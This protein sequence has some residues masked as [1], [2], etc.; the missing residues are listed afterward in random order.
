MESSKDLILVTR[1]LILLVLSSNDAAAALSPEGAQNQVTENKKS[2]PFVATSLILIFIV[3]DVIAFVLVL[4][5]LRAYWESKKSGKRDERKLDIENNK[6]ERPLEHHDDS[7]NRGAASEE[8]GK[9]EFFSEERG[10]ELGDLL[11][12]SADA[13]GKG[14]FG[15]CYKAVLGNGTSV[16]VKRLKDLAPSTGDEF[17]THIRALSALKHPNL[18]SFLAFYNN[19]DERLLVH[20]FARN[21]NLFDRIH[22]GRGENRRGE[23]RVPFKWHSRL[24]VARGVAR[25]MAYLHVNSNSP[26]AAPHGNLKSSNVLLDENDMPR[27]SDYGYSSI[28]STSAAVQRMAVYRSPEY[29][30]RRRVS[31]K[32]DV[33]TYGSLLL[34]L[35]SGK[36]SCL[37]YP[38][39]ERG[40]DLCNWVH[41]AVREEW[42]AEIFDAEIAAQRNASQDMLKLLQ[43]ALRC[44]E[45]SPEQRPEMVDVMRSVEGIAARESG[46]DESSDR[47]SVDD[48][49]GSTNGSGISVE[50]NRKFVSI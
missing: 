21:G 40:I 48:H 10:F 24:Q 17:A 46:D 14:N 28:I 43:I 42:T 7:L 50:Y 38:G 23:N 34:E 26:T 1:L 44:C 32:S 20:R 22:A 3:L 25:A 5:L 18:L 12:A 13:L 15:A 41:V 36:A 2:N 19:R 31:K 9:L 8:R 29:Q 27:V 47:S 37:S 33:W 35:L 16:V 39:G 30:H 49:S 4:L 45:K 6:D 11:K